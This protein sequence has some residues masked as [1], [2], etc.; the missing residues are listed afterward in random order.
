MIVVDLGCREFGGEE[1]INTLTNRFQPKMFYGFDPL[2]E[3]EHFEPGMSLSNKAAWINDGTIWL[4]GGTMNDSTVLP[5][6]HMYQ[7]RHGVEVPCFDFSTWLGGFSENVVLKMDIEGAEFPILEK[8][9]HDG[10]HHMVSYLLVE[11]HER[12]VDGGDARRRK[13]EYRIGCPIELWP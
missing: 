3:E 7:E 8:M 9:I 12:W 11:W 1:S 4:A 10:T 6:S 2:L 13:I 5:E